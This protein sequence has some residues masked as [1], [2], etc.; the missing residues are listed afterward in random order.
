MSAF[1]AQSAEVEDAKGH[2]AS[3]AVYSVLLS[4]GNR[5]MTSVLLIH[6]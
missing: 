4:N 3:S 6:H 5:P 2:V 1:I